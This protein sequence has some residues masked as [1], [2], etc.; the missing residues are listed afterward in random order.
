MSLRQSFLRRGPHLK[1]NIRSFMSHYI[2][3]CTFNCH[4]CFMILLSYIL[5]QSR[6]SF[7]NPSTE[8]Y[9]YWL[10]LNIIRHGLQRYD[11]VNGVVEVEGLKYE[12][13]DEIPAEDRTTEGLLTN[14]RC[15]IFWF[16]LSLAFWILICS[17]LPQK[18]V[19]QAFGSLRWKQMK[20]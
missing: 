8:C 18:K 10:F 19:C 9:W 3:R 13:S 6:K 20:C 1:L 16:G 2:R 11:I 17:T 4:Y 14:L 15:R 12:S 5:V 7:T